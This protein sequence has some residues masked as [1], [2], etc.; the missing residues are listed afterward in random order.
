MT[1][2]LPGTARSWAVIDRPYSVDFLNLGKNLLRQ[3]SVNDAHLAGPSIRVHIFA[4]V[5]FGQLVDVGVCAILRDLDDF[6]FEGKMPVRVLQVLDAQSDIWVA[7]HVE[8]FGA[9]LGAVD[10][11]VRSIEFAPYWRHLR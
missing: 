1:A 7:P 6:A 4:D 3:N 9:A 5:L 8:V 10:D 11:D 2:R